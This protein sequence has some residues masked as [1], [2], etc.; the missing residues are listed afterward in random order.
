MDNKENIQAIADFVISLGW[1]A[2]D[3]AV[4]I[5]EILD[6]IDEKTGSFLRFES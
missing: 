1:T 2:D 3:L 6:A 4:S 5:G